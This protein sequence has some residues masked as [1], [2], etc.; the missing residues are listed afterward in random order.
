MSNRNE[1]KSEQEE[2]KKN[3]TNRTFQSIVSVRFQN[4]EVDKKKNENNLLI[5][6]DSE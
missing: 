3:M 2:Q 5:S 6:S 4:Y 1:D